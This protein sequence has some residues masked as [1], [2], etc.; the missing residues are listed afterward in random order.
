MGRYQMCVKCGTE[1]DTNICSECKE[2]G[3]EIEDKNEYTYIELENG[4]K[5]SEMMKVCTKNK[6]FTEQ[7]VLDLLPKIDGF[8]FSMIEGAPIFKVKPKGEK[9]WVDM[10]TMIVGSNL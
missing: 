8:K 3:E 4:D 1:F 5:A 6:T 10:L 9:E 7:E 2:D